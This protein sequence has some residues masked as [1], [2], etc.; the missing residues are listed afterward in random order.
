MSKKAYKNKEKIKNTRVMVRLDEK[1]ANDLSDLMW[2]LDK[3]KSDILREA[4]QF[5]KERYF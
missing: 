4:L 5:Y 2:F 1:E 3:S